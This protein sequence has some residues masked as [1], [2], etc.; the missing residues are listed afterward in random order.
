MVKGWQQW[1]EFYARLFVWIFGLMLALLTVLQAIPAL[2]GGNALR[3]I[4]LLY[5]FMPAALIV[6]YFDMY[7]LYPPRRRRAK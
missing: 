7:R 5:L 3:L 4:I 2:T 6:W 1:L